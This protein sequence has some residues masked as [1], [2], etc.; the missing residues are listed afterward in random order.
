VRDRVTKQLNVSLKG[1]LSGDQFANG[2]SEGTIVNFN[3][4]EPLAHRL[5]EIKTGF[6]Q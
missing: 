1:A 6:L 5:E 2:V 3:R 4:V